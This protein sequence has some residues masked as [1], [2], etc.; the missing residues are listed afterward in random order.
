MTKN[1]VTVSISF[2]VGALVSALLIANYTGFDL[3]TKYHN[4]PY[5]LKNTIQIK[6][7]KNNKIL[8]LPEGLVLNLKTDYAGSAVVS[9]EL[10]IDLLEL[11]KIA[12]KQE[13][14]FP[15]RYWYVGK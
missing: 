8:N 4:E 2:L 15:N 12:V 1:I 10:I 6:D 14:K 11:E 3:L 7:A 9:T 5:L 13:K